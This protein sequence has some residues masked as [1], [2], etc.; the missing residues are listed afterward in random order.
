MYKHFQEAEQDYFASKGVT[1]LDGI[2]KQNF[3]EMEARRMPGKV[4]VVKFWPDS[5][6]FCNLAESCDRRLAILD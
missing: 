5:K 6:L 2:R 4:G 3:E 1:S